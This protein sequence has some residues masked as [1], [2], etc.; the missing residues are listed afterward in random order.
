MPPK[1]AAPTTFDGWLGSVIEGHIGS[2]GGRPAL[3]KLLHVSDKTVQ[4]KIAGTSAVTVSE[5]ELIAE[6][7]RTP[8]QVIATTALTKYG[9]GDIRAGLLRLKSEVAGS[10]DDLAKKRAEKEPSAEDADE[11]HRRGKAAALDDDRE[12]DDEPGPA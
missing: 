6:M 3:E 5:L 8:A 1:R 4:R 7:V 9:D 10:T 12:P 11:Q 2:Y